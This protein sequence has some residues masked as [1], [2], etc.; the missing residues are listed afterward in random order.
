MVHTTKEEYGQRLKQARMSLGWTQADLAEK[1]NLEPQTVGKYEREGINNTDTL[2]LLSEILSVDLLKDTFEANSP[3]GEI[4]KEILIQLVANDGTMTVGGLLKR[5]LQGLSEKHITGEIVKLHKLGLI[6]REQY[7]DW[8]GE[9]V[10]KLFLTVKGYITIKNMDLNHYQ[11]EMILR[12]ADSLY[13]F[14]SL[15]GPFNSYQDFIDSNE[16][17]KRI[18]NLEYDFMRGG[19]RLNYI[20]YLKRNFETAVDYDGGRDELEDEICPAISCYHDIIYNMVCD[21]SINNLDDYVDVIAGVSDDVALKSFIKLFGK[22][23]KCKYDTS[24]MLENEFSGKGIEN[25]KLSQRN[26][27]IDP[28]LRDSLMQLNMMIDRKNIPEYTKIAKKLLDRLDKNLMNDDRFASIISDVHEAIRKLQFA[29]MLSWNPEEKFKAKEEEHKGV[30]PVNWFS[31]S[32]IREYIELNIRPAGYDPELDQE[33]KEI[34]TLQ[35][36]TL[37]YYTFPYEWEENGLADLV[38]EKVGISKPE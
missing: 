4:G 28:K 38:R 12:H 27:Y 9:D 14:E 30:N 20:K 31:E 34:N 33:L 25:K 19:Y 15:V 35:P 7:K 11:S 6:V 3:I 32:E 2:Q 21:I 1:A 13:T 18:R 5:E 29:H 26:T 8:E 37:N 10:D 36:L 22:V 23:D 16:A 17:E 24:Q